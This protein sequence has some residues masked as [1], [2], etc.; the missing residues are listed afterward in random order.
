MKYII[1]D[2]PPYPFF[3]YSGDALYRPGDCHRKRSGIDCFDLLFVEY[4]SLFMKVGDNY[5]HVKANDM[6]ILPPGQTHEAY[7]VCDEKTYFH[8]LHFNSAGSFQFSNTYS[9]DIKNQRKMPN[10]KNYLETLVCPIFQS[11]SDTNAAN[12]TQI[13]TSLESL[14]INRYLQSSLRRI[15]AFFFCNQ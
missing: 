6:L 10:K 14:R 4:G 13:M 8:W 15:I 5:Y 7:K 12:V 1:F 9:S 2:I 3:V 11:I